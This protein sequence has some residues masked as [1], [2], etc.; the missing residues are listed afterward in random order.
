MKYKDRIYV[1]AMV[2]LYQGRY[3]AYHADATRRSYDFSNR[4]ALQKRT[5]EYHKYLVEAGYPVSK[6]ANIYRVISRV[7]YSEDSAK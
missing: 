2:K 1:E 7:Q 5:R 6:L 4:E 3:K